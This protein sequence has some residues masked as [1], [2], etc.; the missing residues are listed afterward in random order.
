MSEADSWALGQSFINPGDDTTTAPMCARAPSPSTGEDGTAVSLPP[1]TFGYVSLP[2]RVVNHAPN[3]SDGYTTIDR[4]SACSPITN[5]TGEVTSIEYR[6]ARAASCASASLP[7]PDA[8]TTL[9]YSPVT[10]RRPVPGP[11]SRTGST[12]TPSR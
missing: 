1:V 12:S 8:D 5:E 3:F 11:R 9:C 10:G 4:A 6:R 7:T 2:N